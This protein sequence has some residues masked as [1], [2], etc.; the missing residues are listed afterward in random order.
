MDGSR[1]V[2][3]IAL[4]LH[5][6]AAQAQLFSN[7]E[8]GQRNQ[9]LADSLKSTEYPYVMPIWGAKATQ[10]GYNLP[11]PAG[12]SVQYFGSKSDLLINNLMVGF[13][14]GPMYELDGVVR[15]DKAR[16]TASAITAC[17]EGKGYTVK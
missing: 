3:W 1:L 4:L 6:A 11:Y 2:M 12:L 5:P 16:A 10:A 8:V 7:K 13:N 15:F 17:L 14:N 9:Q